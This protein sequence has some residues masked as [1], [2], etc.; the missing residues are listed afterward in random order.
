MEPEND[1]IYDLIAKS[2]SGELSDEELVYLNNWKAADNSNLLEY[3]DFKEIWKSS[4]RLAMPSPLDLTKLLVSTRNK[5]GIDRRLIRW[6]PVFTQIAAVLIFSLLFSSL[7][8]LYLTPKHLEKL[9]SPVYQQVKASF[10]IKSRVELSD[11]TVVYLNSGSSLRF[12]N[13]F[14]SMKNRIVELSGEGH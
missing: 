10:G 11:G 7:Y 9:E 14:K 4:N 2:F 6:F 12:P 5:A 8:N 13:S 3:N 1:Q